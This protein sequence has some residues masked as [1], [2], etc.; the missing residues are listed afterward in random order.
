MQK[1]VKTKIDQNVKVG[2][3]LSHYC[4]ECDSK[5]MPKWLVNNSWLSMSLFLWALWALRLCTK[6]LDGNTENLK[7]SHNIA[8]KFLLLREVEKLAFWQKVNANKCNGGWDLEITWPKR[9]SSGRLNWR[10]P[11]EGVVRESAL[12]GCSASKSVQKG[13]EVAQA[14]SRII[15]VNIN[16]THLHGKSGQGR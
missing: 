4:Y 10:R 3:F 6:H 9:H 16:N 7:N 15:H 12:I 11:S 5:W 1:K 14:F 8:K 2:I 13:E